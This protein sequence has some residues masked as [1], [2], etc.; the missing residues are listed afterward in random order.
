MNSVHAVWPRLTVGRPAEGGNSGQPSE[1]GVFFGLR[2]WQGSFS[3]DC[4]RSVEGPPPLLLVQK[5]FLSGF[6]LDFLSS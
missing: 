5:Q 1:M 6:V 4:R 2:G 3:F